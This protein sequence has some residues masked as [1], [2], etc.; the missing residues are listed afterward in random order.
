M[1]L[2]NEDVPLTIRHYL[3][4]ARTCLCGGSCFESYAIYIT[5]IDL[6]RVAHTITADV[7]DAGRM[8]APAEG[9]ICSKKC[10]NKWHK[11][12]NALWH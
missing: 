7:L 2:S 11:R 12:P 10:Y 1:A 8:S 9:Y 4:T 3:N 6:G 5:M